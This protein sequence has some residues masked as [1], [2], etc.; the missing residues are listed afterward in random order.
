MAWITRVNTVLSR[1]LDEE[2]GETGEWS[3][4]LSGVGEHYTEIVFILLLF[5]LKGLWNSKE[6]E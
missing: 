1:L 2:M 3:K 5:M 4:A 6:R